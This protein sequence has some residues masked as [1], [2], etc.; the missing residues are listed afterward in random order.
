[1]TGDNRSAVTYE[2]RAFEK[3]S[4]FLRKIRSRRDLSYGCRA[5]KASFMGVAGLNTGSRRDLVS[6]DQVSSEKPCF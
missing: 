6:R 3:K 4:E 2:S 5:S 1:M